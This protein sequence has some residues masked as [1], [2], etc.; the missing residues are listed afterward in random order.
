MTEVSNT[1]RRPHGWGNRLDAFGWPWT[2]TNLDDG[3][4]RLYPSEL[5]ALWGEAMW[6]ARDLW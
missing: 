4:R 3:M 1:P 5:A 2:L 6:T